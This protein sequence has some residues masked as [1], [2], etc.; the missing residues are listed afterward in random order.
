M[1]NTYPAH[2][3]FLAI[4]GQPAAD[5]LSSSAKPAHSERIDEFGSYLEDVLWE[6]QGQVFQPMNPTCCQITYY[7]YLG[8]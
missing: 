6:H 2:H 4:T 5:Y 8:F 1:L 7:F 3:L